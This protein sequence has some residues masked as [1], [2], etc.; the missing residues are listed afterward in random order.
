MIRLLAIDI[1][2]TLYN[3]R[4]EISLANRVAL[5]KA[6]LAGIQTV[7]ITGRGRKDTESVLDAL[8]EDLGYIC[9]AGSLIRP[10]KSGAPIATRTFHA[11]AEL[12][13]VIDFARRMDAGLLAET[14]EFNGWF[15]SQAA[16]ASLDPKTLAYITEHCVRSYQPEVDFDQPL[17]KVTIVAAPALLT[18]AGLLMDAQ[19]PSLNHT[20]SGH[21]YCDVTGRGVDKGSALAL[22]ADWLGLSDAG[23]AAIGDQP[24]DIPMLRYAGISAAMGNAVEGVKS[25]AKLVAP[26]HDDDGVA[27]FVDY[28]LA[29]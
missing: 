20:Y 18:E 3:S 28:I 24:I 5:K 19:C 4:Q 22:L 26:S 9:S 27:W 6:R 17:L 25:S 14:P 11:M 2:G 16:E 8:G 13:Q 1:D 23:V 15:G 29:M 12:R 10:G 7:L 21:H